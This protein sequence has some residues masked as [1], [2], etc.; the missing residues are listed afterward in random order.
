MAEAS[1][2]WWIAGVIAVVL[3]LLLAKARAFYARFRRMCRGIREE[4]T[5][6]LGEDHPDAKVLREEHGNLIVRMPDGSERVW[7]MEE[8]YTAVASLPGMGADPVAR[9]RV[10]RDALNA[11]FPPAPIAGPLTLEAHGDRIRPRLVLPE[12]L[13]E[14][15]ADGGLLHLPL[16]ELG[17][18]VVYVAGVPPADRLLTEQ[19]RTTLGLDV[20]ALHRRALENLRRDFPGE[21][22]RPALEQG[23]GSAI[24]AHDSFD[25]SRLLLI[26]ERLEPGQELVALAPHQDLLL[27][28]P[29]S[30]R[31]D[32]KKAGGGTPDGRR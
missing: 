6:L 16:P 22:L 11:L 25:A 5:Q 13:G 9:A 26:P 19:D 23:S 18:E 20:E 7:E 2:G 3:L 30:I 29:A 24:Q 12:A 21:M 28:L 1:V 10:Y 31:E 14:L 17:L 32:P 4:L 27:L 8:I 15:K